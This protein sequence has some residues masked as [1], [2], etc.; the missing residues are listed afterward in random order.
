MSC[1][2]PDIKALLLFAAVGI[3]VISLINWWHAAW[4]N[5]HIKIFCICS[6]VFQRT[7]NKPHLLCNHKHVQRSM[8]MAFRKQEGMIMWMCAQGLSRFGLFINWKSMFCC[9]TIRCKVQPLS[10]P[11][12]AFFNSYFL[13]DIVH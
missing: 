12:L 5:M 10:L 3:F 6:P 2:K 8:L 4:I 9:L 1:C 7:Y 11:S 13:L